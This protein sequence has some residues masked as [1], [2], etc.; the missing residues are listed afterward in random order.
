MHPYQCWKR[1]P[2]IL[3]Y[4]KSK[5]LFRDPVR[6]IFDVVV[7]L[8]VQQEIVVN[9]ITIF[10]FGELLTLAHQAAREMRQK[11]R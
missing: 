2:K 6:L 8:D 11:M 10:K 1:G 7:V 9:I 3:Q 4:F 5:K